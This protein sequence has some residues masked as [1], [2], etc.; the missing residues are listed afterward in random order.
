MAKRKTRIGDKEKEILKLIAQG[1]LISASLVVPNL[2]I[3]LKPFLD[4]R[5]K[6]ERFKKSI[7]RLEG[8]D[9]IFLSGEKIKLSKKGQKM[10]ERFA[11]E[12]IT[13]KTDI[14]WD[15]IWRIVAYDI[16]DDFKKERDYFRRKLIGLGFET[17]QESLMVIPYEC[18]EEIAVFAHHL[19]VAPF[20]MFLTTDKLPRQK[21]MI[22]KFGLDENI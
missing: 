18:K 9:L 13:I 11:S 5:R 8:K 12:D 15:G 22:K 3:A 16:P 2:P 21:D 10:L 20:V 14:G 7:K 17:I 19:H 6:R 4:N 1:V